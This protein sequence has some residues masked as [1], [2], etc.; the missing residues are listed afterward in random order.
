[1]VN[2]LYPT[3][4]FPLAKGTDTYFGPVFGN[5]AIKISII[6]ILLT[7]LGER[8]SLP[9]FGS[10]IHELIFERNTRVFDVLMEEYVITAIR[11]WEPRVAIQSVST[12]RFPDSNRVR[13]QIFFVINRPGQQI[14]QLGLDLNSQLGTITPSNPI[15]L[16]TL[17]I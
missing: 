16:R 2:N 8:V 12:T 9:E 5:D 14:D 3:I 17:S 10:R 4:K 13:V 1:M 7:E 15:N 6:T 11:R